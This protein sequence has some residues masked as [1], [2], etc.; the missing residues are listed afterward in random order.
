M[1]VAVLTRSYDNTRAG[2]NTEES[3][4]TPTV[5]ARGLRKLFSFEVD[6]DPRLEAQPL[7]VPGVKLNDGSTHDV[8]YVC[9]MANNVV[10]MIV[11]TTIKPMT[12]IR[13]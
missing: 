5:V 13:P 4:L 7:I 1:A 9:T 12:R 10:I 2:A 6:D 3:T 8:V 11:I